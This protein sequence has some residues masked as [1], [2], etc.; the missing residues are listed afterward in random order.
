MEVVPSRSAVWRTSHVIDTDIRTVRSLR[1]L[2]HAVR[3]DI[4]AAPP[5]VNPIFSATRFGLVLGDHTIAHTN[6]INIG[7]Y[8]TADAEAS[9]SSGRFQRKRYTRHHASTGLTISQPAKR[10]DHDTTQP[11]GAHRFH[12]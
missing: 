1:R 5:V 11:Q 8:L 2:A 12:L 6:R 4:G 7:T 9:V 10:S 3:Q